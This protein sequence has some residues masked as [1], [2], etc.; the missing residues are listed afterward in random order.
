MILPA[1]LRA[2]V[3]A[4]AFGGGLL[5][6]AAAQT[7]ES[8]DPE[9][10]GLDPRRLAEGVER[11][12]RAGGVRCLLVARRGRL[13]EERCWGGARPDRPHD[14]KSASKSL[15]SAL[16]G[17]ALDR[18]VLRDVDQAIAPLLGE[19]L[20]EEPGARTEITV[21]HLLTM[22][23]GLE[24]TS[25]AGYGRWVASG[26][27]ARYAV[28]RPLE[29]PP[30]SRFA[31][32]TGNTHLLGT[33]LARAAGESL[34][35]FAARHLFGPLGVRVSAWQRAPE[36]THFGGNSLSLSPRALARFGQLYLDGGRIGE[37]QL[38]PRG[39]IAESTR[40]HAVG[41]PDRYGGYGYL[42]WVRPDDRP[43]A[44]AAVGY[45]GQFLYVVPELE[46][47]VVLT[48]SHGG[49]GAA[50][51]RRMLGIFRDYLA[52]SVRPSSSSWMKRS[53]SSWEASGGA[54]NSSPSRTLP[55]PGE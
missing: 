25:G 47:L 35:D 22:T 12:S 46:L 49:K 9:A 8:G 43:P 40:R 55:A 5:G 24:S 30:G 39:W 23:S 6:P 1:P 20:P 31:Y 36:G 54:T 53:R 34:L 51:D 42:W 28:R 10:L 26:D 4:A 16:V 15:L 29:A 48:S 2:L 18:G 33:V 19:E 13:V 32:S 45:G 11:V 3:V 38:V 21:R 41:W 14:V 44:F 52:G 7:W 27:W 17:I 37:R 50:W